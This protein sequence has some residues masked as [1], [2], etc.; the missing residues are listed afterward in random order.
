MN[1][2]MRLSRWLALGSPSV[3][4]LGVLCE[5]VLHLALGV[6]WGHALAPTDFPDHDPDGVLYRFILRSKTL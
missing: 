6:S 5:T 3:V 2:E 1:E 4:V